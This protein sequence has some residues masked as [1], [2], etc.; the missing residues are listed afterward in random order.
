MFLFAPLCLS[1]LYGANNNCTLG[2]LRIVLGAH[3]VVSANPSSLWAQ[4]GPASIA[5]R[6][7]PSSHRLLRLLSVGAT[8]RYTPIAPVTYITRTLSSLHDCYSIVAK[9]RLKTGH[10]RAMHET[11]VVTA[12]VSN[13][14]ASISGDSA[15]SDDWVTRSQRSLLRLQLL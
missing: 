13:R 8:V 14:R 9:A 7:P 5:I 1:F 3:L 4:L 12:T 6:F 2:D 15:P 10:S 11:G